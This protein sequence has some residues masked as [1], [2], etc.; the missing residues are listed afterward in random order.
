MFK[1]SGYTFVELLVVIALIG[2]LASMTL[3][4][5][6]SMVT[7][8]S[9][10][11]E[12]ESLAA[13]ISYLQTSARASQTTIH[14]V[15][16][17]QTISANFYS[18][19]RSNTLVQNGASPIALDAQAQTNGLS[20]QDQIIFNGGVQTAMHCPAF[21]GDVYISSEGY[22]LTTM[23]CNSIDF[24]FTKNTS[25]DLASKLSL[26]NLGYPRIYMQSTAVSNNW[27]ELL[28]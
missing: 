27:N 26:S 7:S 18:G 4:R 22:L 12:A 1:Q 5:S 23:A 2:V 28:K 19:V 21:C 13:K 15:C 24:I 14:L 9:L 10:L 6:P 17:S 20:H 25:S 11:S 16:S 3:F 8:R